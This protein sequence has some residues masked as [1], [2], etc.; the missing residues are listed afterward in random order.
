VRKFLQL[1][2][3]AW[4]SESRKAEPES[5]IEA[6]LLTPEFSDLR[7]KIRCIAPWEENLRYFL[8][9]ISNRTGILGPYDGPESDWRFWHRTFQEALT[10]EHLFQEVDRGGVRVCIDH[11]RNVSGRQLGYWAEPYALLAGSLD[12]PDELLKAIM[13][14]NPPLGF[15]ALATVQR[16]SDVTLLELLGFTPEIVQRRQLIESIPRLVDDPERALSLLQRIFDGMSDI[17]DLFFLDEALGQCEVLYPENTAVIRQLRHH[18]LDS[19]ATPPEDLFRE[20]RTRKGVENLERC[21]T[22][23]ATTKKTWP[24]LRGTGTIPRHILIQLAGRTPMTSGFTTCTG[25]YG[26]G[27]QMDCD[28]TAPESY[29]TPLG[30]RTKSVVLYAAVASIPKLPLHV[31]PAVNRAPLIFDRMIKDFESYSHTR[32][33]NRFQGL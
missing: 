16:V 8:E 1:L 29:A 33:V 6:R 17:N 26:S 27:A 19:L 32:R 30:L 23:R 9:D 18:L 10:A 13:S 25:T 4:T 15:R 20:I 3:Y 28:D 12:E 31:A 5:D 11:A 2:A 21:C 14:A 7:N 24:E 22:T